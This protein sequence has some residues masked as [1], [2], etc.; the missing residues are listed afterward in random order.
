[1]AKLP[2]PPGP[3]ALAAR[4]GAELR[5]LPAGTLVWRLY[6]RGG[7]H[8]SG[9]SDLRRFGPVPSM[10]FDHHEPPPRAQDRGILYAALRVSTCM[11]E[12]FQETRTI[13]R[14]RE[15]PWLAGFALDR[16]VAAL[17][18]S[19]NWPTR[20]GASM[21]L[22]SGRHDRSRRW[23]R[24]IYEDYPEVEGL[25]YPSSMDGNQPALAFYERARSALPARPAFH[26][27]LADP[28]LDAAVV[29]AALAFGY[30]VEP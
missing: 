27:A 19:G 22:S 10:R 20:A 8:P 6:R 28:G 29:R 23:S 3:G 30:L 11:A 5:V 2:E 17:D 13:E 25:Y 15:R 1:M 18:L 26:R 4:L 24:R 16:D 12:V 21:V 7:A 9:W 14:S